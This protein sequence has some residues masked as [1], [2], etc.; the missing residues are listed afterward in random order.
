MRL[1]IFLCDYYL[2]SLVRRLFRAFAQCFKWVVHFPVMLRVLH[3]F[4][5]P[6]LFF[7]FSFFLDS[8]HSHTR[9]APWLWGRDRR[10]RIFCRLQ[11]GARGRAP[12]RDP[13][14]A[15]S[16]LK[17]RVGRPTDRA[18]QV[19]QMTF[20]YQICILQ[21]IFSLSVAYLLIFSTKSWRADVLTSVRPSWSILL[22][23]DL[24]LSRLI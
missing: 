18:T 3:I 21:D 20:L 10:E 7:S 19:P 16:E 23:Y 5:M 4:W 15:K 11:C 12:S 1:D 14:I 22:L 6:F 24:C 8:E 2:L 17:S 9:A 13:E